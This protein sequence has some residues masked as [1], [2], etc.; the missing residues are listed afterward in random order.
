MESIPCTTDLLPITS[1]RLTFCKCVVPSS[2]C[3]QPAGIGNFSLGIDE[4][5]IW[6]HSRGHHFSFSVEIV[7][8]PVCPFPLGEKG[9][10]VDVIEGFAVF[11]D[12]TSIS[13]FFWCFFSH[14]ACLI[15]RSL[16]GFCSCFRSLSG[17]NSCC[18]LSGCRFLSGFC[19][20][21]LSG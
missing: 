5:A 7:P 20:N 16:S 15:A 4:I 12:E 14:L 18:W 17:L 1:E 3:V 6:C 11:V 2:I 21:C 19:M 10:T 8:A 13:G 9:F